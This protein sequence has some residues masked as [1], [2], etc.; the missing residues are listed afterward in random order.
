MNKINVPD[1]I[2]YFYIL[3]YLIFLIFCYSSLSDIKII[4][5]DNNTPNFILHI[6][7]F[8]TPIF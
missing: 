3:I 5:F 4:N 6:C 2:F 7:T 8:K 1:I